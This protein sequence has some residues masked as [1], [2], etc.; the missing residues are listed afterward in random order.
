MAADTDPSVKGR[1]T[2]LLW[3]TKVRG[4]QHP[5][6]CA[7]FL[8]STSTSKKMNAAARGHPVTASETRQDL[9]GAGFLTAGAAWLRDN[10]VGAKTAPPAVQ[11]VPG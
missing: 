2:Y 4:H 10:T 11:C 6:C 8:H 3:P 5:V 7:P 9:A 1:D